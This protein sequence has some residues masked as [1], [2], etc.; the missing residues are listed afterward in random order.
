[1]SGGYWLWTGAEYFLTCEIARSI[2]CKG[3]HNF[4][5]T[6]E[7]G[8]AN[9]SFG[10][11]RPRQDARRDGRG[12]IAV[13][14]PQEKLLAVVEVKNS[15]PAAA[16]KGDI[17]RLIDIAAGSKEPVVSILAYYFSVEEEDAEKCEAA[18]QRRGKLLDQRCKKALLSSGMK[19]VIC[20]SRQEICKP[21]YTD[22][23]AGTVSMAMGFIATFSRA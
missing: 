15:V 10:K 1:M 19:K 12:D 7:E 23:A 2:Y 11:G 13:W 21:W 9:V 14:S 3:S 18:L 20:K 17:A 16:C 8:I 4:R 5:C 22:Q 6:V